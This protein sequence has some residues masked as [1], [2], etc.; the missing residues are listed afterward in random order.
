MDV[1]IVSSVDEIKARL[2]HAGFEALLEAADAVVDDVQN[3]TEGH[4]APVDTGAL[5]SSYTTEPDEGSLSVLVGSDPAVI[6]PVSGQS[7][8]TYAAPVEYG[9]HTASG[10][11]VPAQPSFTPA[12]EYQATTLERRIAG[13]WADVG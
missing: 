2:Y 12:V 13:K 11:W 9:H 6:N 5:A 8:G 1:T 4:G 7:V 10:S 3:G